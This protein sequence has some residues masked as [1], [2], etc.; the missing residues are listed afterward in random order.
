[1]KVNITAPMDHALVSSA[2]ADVVDI[3]TETVGSIRQ[4]IHDRHDG[5]IE[6]EVSDRRKMGSISRSASYK[7]RV[8]NPRRQEIGRLPPPRVRHRA[9][10]DTL[11]G[12]AKCAE[13]VVSGKF[14]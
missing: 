1:M 6:V 14:P 5:R 13:T 11:G 3:V 2:F 7:S 10:T 8:T 4:R 12:E 9:K